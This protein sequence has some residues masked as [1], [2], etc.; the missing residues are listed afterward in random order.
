MRG[1]WDYFGDEARWVAGLTDHLFL[2]H[3]RPAQPGEICGFVQST[4][5]RHT[6]ILYGLQTREARVTMVAAQSSG[7]DEFNRRAFGLAIEG[8]C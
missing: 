7:L 4:D 8:I 2:R 5:L 1:S 3:P 6:P